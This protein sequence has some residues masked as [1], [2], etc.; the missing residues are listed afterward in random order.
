M[1]GLDSFCMVLNAS[2]LFNCR[3][4]DLQHIKNFPEAYFIIVSFIRPLPLLIFVILCTI[5]LNLFLY[6]IER[7]KIKKDLSMTL[8]ERNSYL[9]R[10]L[11]QTG[12]LSNHLRQ[13]LELCGNNFKFIGSFMKD[14]VNHCGNKTLNQECL[15]CE[16][17]KH[18]NPNKLLPAQKEIVYTILC[19]QRRKGTVWSILSPD[20][21]RY[22]L[23]K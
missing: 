15:C 7:H 6:H 18:N 23:E 19:M 4:E 11:L 12:D 21:T 5:L 9:E 13:A 16:Y 22:F 10:K 20:V 1:K 14:C 3:S 2:Y 17:Y 8:I